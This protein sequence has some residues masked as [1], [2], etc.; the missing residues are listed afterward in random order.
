MTHS[1]YP[2][3][4]MARTTSLFLSLKG[5]FSSGCLERVFKKTMTLHVLLDYSLLHQCGGSRSRVLPLD[6]VTIGNFSSALVWSAGKAEE[7]DMS[8]AHV[9]FSH[10]SPCGSGERQSEAI[11]SSQTFSNFFRMLYFSSFCAEILY[12]FPNQLHAKLQPLFSWEH[13]DSGSDC[14]VWTLTRKGTSPKWPPFPHV[15]NVHN[16]SIS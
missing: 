3:T 6:V 5:A 15:Y 2:R 7:N 10:K 13:R 8:L 1:H 4:V 11:P 14:L 16:K 12:A 9:R